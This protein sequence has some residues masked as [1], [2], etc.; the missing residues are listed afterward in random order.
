[1]NSIHSARRPAAGSGLRNFHHALGQGVLVRLPSGS[2]RETREEEIIGNDTRTKVNGFYVPFRWIC[3]LKT[4]FRD[5]DSQSQ[6]VDFD[7]GSGLLIGPNCVLTAAHNI[8]AD[9]TGSR[10]TVQRQE[11]LFTK[12][13]PGRRDGNDF[14]FGNAESEKFFYLQNFKP[15]LD[16]RFDYA[17]IKLK[18]SIGNKKFKALQG[19]PLG[20]WGSSSWGAGTQIRA[21]SRTYLQNLIVNVAGYPKDKNHEPYNAWDTIHN[22]YPTVHRASVPASLPNS[23]ARRT[24][25]VARLCGVTGKIPASVAWWRSIT[26]PVC[27]LWMAARLE[28]FFELGLD[29]SRR[30]QSA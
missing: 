29:H 3:S 26:E 24:V 28:G 25:R 11:A 21:L 5:P 20:W 4:R 16:V 22:S 23:S 1:M 9:I 14:P 2:A 27:R 8:Y 10:G 12:V 6:V 13:Y 19:N 15:N 17:L 7:Q 30:D 18:S